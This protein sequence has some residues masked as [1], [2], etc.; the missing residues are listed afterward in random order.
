MRPAACLP[1]MNVIDTAAR[2][3][4]PSPVRYRAWFGLLLG[5]LVLLV[6]CVSVAATPSTAHCT[7]TA[8]AS[9]AS[10][11]PGD[12]IPDSDDRAGTHV[13]KR[14]ILPLAVETEATDAPPAVASPVFLSAPPTPN[15][16][17]SQVRRDFAW[18]G[19]D[20]RLRLRPARQAPPG[21]AP[22]R[23]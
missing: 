18:A 5:L 6:P 7:E 20:A 3:A 17:T 9:S 2:L 12:R 15:L 22:P 14:R 11:L 13:G 23:A 19:P 1:G 4:S 16:P 10:A 21:H 8:I